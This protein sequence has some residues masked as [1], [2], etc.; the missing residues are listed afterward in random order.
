MDVR[1]ADLYGFHCANDDS[2]CQIYGVKN[3]SNT[4]LIDGCIQSCTRLSPILQ[5]P[6]VGCF[7]LASSINPGGKSDVSHFIVNS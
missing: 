7:C 1:K 4:I 6:V 5:S 3:S 2:H